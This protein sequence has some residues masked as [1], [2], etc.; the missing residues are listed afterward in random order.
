MKAALIQCP[1]WGRQCPPYALACLA[2][3][4]RKQGHEVLCLDLNNPLYLASPKKLQAMWDDKDYYSFWEN[5]GRVARLLLENE[6]L[7]NRAVEKILDW[8]ADVVGF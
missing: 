7:L 4:L 1:G 8:G 2:A 6:G 3:Y 5:P